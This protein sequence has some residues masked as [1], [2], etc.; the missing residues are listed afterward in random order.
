MAKPSASSTISS[1]IPAATL[2]ALPATY[3]AALKELDGLVAGLES[4]QLPLD[5][6]LS[7][8]QR[9]AQLLAFCKGKLEAVETQIKV[10]EGTELKPWA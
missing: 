3:E 8:Y 7:G 6:L 1:A 10:L 5:Q 4:G 2:P 9:G